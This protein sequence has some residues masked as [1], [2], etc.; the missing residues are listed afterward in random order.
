LQEAVRDG[1][2]EIAR[3]LIVAG[4]SLN[5]HDGKDKETLLIEAVYKGNIE[6]VKLLIDYG[7]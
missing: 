7:V 2:I 3:S 1:N 6:I 5:L 4:A